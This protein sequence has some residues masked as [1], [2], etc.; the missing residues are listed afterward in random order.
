MNGVVVVLGRQGAGKGT[1]CGLLQDRY[2]GVAHVSTGDML[3]DA[4]ASGTPLGAHAEAIMATG[5]LVPD[6]VMC[7]VVAERL[8][9]LDRS[10]VTV[11]LDGFPRTPAQ[12]E[13]LAGM[14][15]PD[16]LLGAVLLEVDV[17]EVSERMQARG[18]GDD[19]AEGIARRLELYETQTAPLVDWF[20]ERGL[21]RRINGTGEPAEVFD[22]LATA[23]GGLVPL[24]LSR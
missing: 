19:T 9:A 14:T 1:Q 11:L 15:A 3:R 8:A 16:G 18:R 7:D 5:D 23:I 4:A 21:L 13:A 20:A 22:R 6:D 17:R 24:R 10:G 2:D 12:A